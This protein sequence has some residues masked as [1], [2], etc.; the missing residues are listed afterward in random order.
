MSVL[1]YSAEQE[2]VPSLIHPFVG[3]AQGASETSENECADIQKVNSCLQQ[4]QCP[5]ELCA[6]AIIESHVY[7]C[8]WL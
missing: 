3:S 7:V 4:D 8:V 2:C 5:W 6:I 1:L